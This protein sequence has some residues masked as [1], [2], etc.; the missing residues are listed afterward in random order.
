MNKNRFIYISF[1][2]IPLCL[3][4]TCEGCQDSDEDYDEYDWD[5]RRSVPDDGYLLNRE[6]T[7]PDLYPR[8]LESL[9]P[10]MIIDDSDVDIDD[11]QS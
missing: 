3:G 6:K 8:I 5:P 2:Y 10:D 1:V 9:N 7:N 4:E 11:G